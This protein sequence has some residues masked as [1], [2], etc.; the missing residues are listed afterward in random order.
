[1][2]DAIRTPAQRQQRLGW[3]AIAAFGVG[4]LLLWLASPVKQLVSEHLMPHIAYQAADQGFSAG[5]GGLPTLVKDGGGSQ[6]VPFQGAADVAH[7]DEFRGDDWLLGNEAGHWTLQVAV[8][9]REQSAKALLAGLANR[10]YFRYFFLPDA[11]GGRF[12]MVT[13]DYATRAEAEAAAVEYELPSA[14][15]PRNWSVYQ[16]ELRSAL[17]TSPAKPSTGTLSTPAG[18]EPST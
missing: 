16:D 8:M 12:V 6:P 2:A 13:G 4:T 14:P 18:G 5:F 7:A 11:R 1:M 17:T 10:D 9:A 3:Q 15:L